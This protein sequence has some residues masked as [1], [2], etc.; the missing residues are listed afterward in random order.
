MKTIADILFL[1][2]YLIETR[3]YLHQHPETGFDVL[4][5]HDFVCRELTSMGIE[6]IPHVGKNSVLGIISNGL[7]PILGLRADMDAL[8]MQE[9]NQTL[10]Y[11][12]QNEGKM[13]ARGHDA[14]TSMLLG[15]AKYL[16]SFKNEWNGTVKLIFQEA[17]E[18]PNPGGAYGFCLSGLLDD[19]ES[20]FALHVSSAYPSG[21]LALKFGEAMASADTIKIHLIGK[22]CHAAYPHLGIDP[23]VMQAETILALQTIVSRKI[24]PVESTVVT[25]AKVQSGSTHNVIPES[26][27]L[28]GTVRTFN[29]VTRSQVEKE[30]ETVLRGVTSAHGGT[31]RF[32]Y[33]REYDP[34]IN[35]PSE[36]RY[37]QKIVEGSLGKG[38]FFELLKPS[39]GAEDFS[40]YTA[41][42]KGCIGWL[43]TKKDPSTSYPIHH[44]FFNIDESNLKNGTLILVNLV[45]NYERDEQR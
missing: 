15:A 31:F 7:G 19:V 8:P 10:P 11:C 13:H 5:T 45:E 18:G 36:C 30:I 34:T 27:Y 37:F 20:F 43:G 28:E 38:T 35:T 6:F 33:L 44:P 14:H 12:S 9:A 4:N 39:M 32:E 25:I 42:K 3:R 17:E 29:E 23:I 41:M 1:E 22:G 40:R 26:A 24:D 2:S 16:S 21:T